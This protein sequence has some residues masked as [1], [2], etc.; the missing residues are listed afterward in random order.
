MK[1]PSFA[2]VE[3]LIAN[4]EATWGVCVKLLDS[5]ETCYEHNA[6]RPFEAA[7]INK[8]PIALY[9]LAEVDRGR[10]SLQD[11]LELSEE[12]KLPG[13]GLLQYLSSGMRYSLGDLLTLMLVTSDNTAAKM[14]V[15]RFTP[16]SVNRY[17][18]SLGLKVTRLG[19]GAEGKFSYG[20]T[21]PREQATILEG[22]YKHRYLSQP[23]SR[24]LVGMMA[25]CRFTLGIKRYLPKTQRNKDLVVANKEGTLND[26][27]HEVALVCAVEPYAMTVFSEGL[28]DTAYSVDNAG[29]VMIGQIAQ[30]V[31]AAV[32]VG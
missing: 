14:L 5:G 29:V 16:A 20:Q 13:T 17:L 19:V 31:H 23:L 18:E 6:D 12:L 1:S 9:V 11:T 3:R 27:R 32:A 15:Q 24:D 30:T 25:K 21:T 4:S 22:I 26:L 28:K 2:A 10:A 7:S 8:V